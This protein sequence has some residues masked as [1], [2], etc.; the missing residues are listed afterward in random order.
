MLV[1]RDVV[2]SPLS[3]NVVWFSVFELTV[4]TRH[5]DR[6]TDGWGIA[7]NAASYRGRLHNSATTTTLFD[8]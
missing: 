1:T 2:A 7:H 3:F 8:L 4:N 6:Q 5:T